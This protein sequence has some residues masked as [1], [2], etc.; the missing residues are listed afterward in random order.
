MSRLRYQRLSK[1]QL[2]CELEIARSSRVKNRVVSGSV[3]RLGPEAAI[4]HAGGGTESRTVESSIL[5]A[6]AGVI[7]HV[8]HVGLKPKADALM[9]GE[10]AMYGE[11]QLLQRESTDDVTAEIAGNGLR[12]N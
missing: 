10:V 8:R 4:C 11:I 6:E 12:S 9:D 2:H 7:E 3:G 5:R 1:E